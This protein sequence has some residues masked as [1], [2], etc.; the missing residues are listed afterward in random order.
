MARKWKE[1]KRVGRN[2]KVAEAVNSDIYDIFSTS[3]STFPKTSGQGRTATRFSEMRVKNGTIELDYKHTNGACH[4]N[5][6]MEFYYGYDD[7]IG[8]TVL[9]LLAA[10]EE[11]FH[12]TRKSR[13]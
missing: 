2:R 9:A 1:I 10:L 4:L 11:I 5:G 6:T 13:D 12:R 8:K 7:E 3:R